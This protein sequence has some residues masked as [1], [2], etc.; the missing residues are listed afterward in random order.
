M[1]QN[2]ASAIIGCAKKL[3]VLITI[4]ALLVSIITKSA[5]ANS[6]YDKFNGRFV[7][8]SNV[9]NSAESDLYTADYDGSN[10]KRMTN[11]SQHDGNP[12]WHPNGQRIIFDSPKD[13]L[14]GNSTSHSIFIMNTDGS[15]KKLL[16]DQ[17]QAALG[18]TLCPD[19][20]GCPLFDP[21]FS[22]DGSKI[23]FHLLTSNAGSTGV[24]I[25]VANYDYASNS[26]N[27]LHY[28]SSQSVVANHEPVWSSDGTK[29]VAGYIAPDDSRRVKVFNVSDGSLYYESPSGPWSHTPQFGPQQGKNLV[30]VGQPNGKV[31]VIDIDTRQGE[32]EPFYILQAA[33]GI[34]DSGAYTWSP[35][36][37]KIAR[38][39]DD[40]TVSIID[41]EKKSSNTFRIKDYSG[42]IMELDWG[43]GEPTNLPDVYIECETEVGKSCTKENIPEYCTDALLTPPA[44]GSSQI[45]KGGSGG[46]TLTYTPKES[47]SKEEN[48]VYQREDLLGNSAKCFVKIKFKPAPTV[49]TTGMLGGL[50]TILTIAGFTGSFIYVKDRRAKRSKSSK[51]EK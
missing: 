44:R 38:G 24:K 13:G 20:N 35:N 33:A 51:S 22:P 29:I 1:L 32:S 25:V 11:D 27:S 31:F 2:S 46:S 10:V 18:N 4:S 36:G 28:L 48:Y 16:Q 39:M 42:R 26:I 14:P 5:S 12:Q 40:G 7:W 23:A 21:S 19:I 6:S 15:A 49:P 9:I 41:Y 45:K 34:A 50:I 17:T 43:K 37:K 47:S 30:V 8:Y 3:F